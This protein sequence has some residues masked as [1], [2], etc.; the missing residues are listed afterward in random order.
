VLGTP[1]FDALDREFDQ[2]SRL[3]HLDGLRIRG[4]GSH[5]IGP[6]VSAAAVAWAV[7][8]VTTL[9]GPVVTTS[10]TVPRPASAV[11]AVSAVPSTPV[12]RRVGPAVPAEANDGA[13]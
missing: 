11:S 2:R 1:F 9:D 8:D 12:V 10:P 13:D 4:V 7:D 6:L 5:Q 3:G